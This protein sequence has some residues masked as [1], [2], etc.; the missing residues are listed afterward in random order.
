MK[1]FLTTPIF[2]VNDVPHIGHAYCVLATDVLARFWRSKLGAE[3]VY[4]LT[5]TDENSQKTLDAAEKSGQKVD[6]Y[7]EKMATSWRQTWEKC[8]VSF[9]DFIRTTEKRHHQKVAQVLEKMHRAG[10]IYPG[11]YT[12][13]YCTGCETFL[14]DT[15]LNERGECPDHLKKPQILEEKNYFFRLSKY[16]D[17]LLEFYAKNPNFLRPQKRK[18]EVLAFI[19][20]GLEDISI[21]REGA[22]IGIE[23][24]FDANHRIYVWVEALINYLSACPSDDFWAGA[25]HIV[26]KDIT[27]FH[28]IIWPAMLFSAGISVPNAEFAHGYFTIDGQKMSKS[29]GNVISPLELAEKFG[30]DALRM[31]L[32]ASF[33]FG[34]DGDFGAANFENFYRSQLAGGVGNLFNR[35]VVLAH[36]FFDGQKPQN[37]E[38][39]SRAD[40]E[41][42]ENFLTN[43]EIRGAISFFF[44]KVSDANEFLSRSEIWKT[45]KT[46]PAKA[47]KDF[48]VLAGRLEFLAQMSEILLPKSF[49]KMQKMLGDE[50][51]FGSPEILF[52]EIK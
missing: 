38:N 9:D 48:G 47:Q 4:F 24:P 2:Y 39:V 12:G 19:K 42:F 51:N 20:R 23:F 16:E 11:K 8:D 17:Q 43:F 46:E 27:K 30:T 6:E 18:N 35:V 34:N 21:S 31:G 5:G 13:K 49:G 33:E 29:L 1:K 10:D 37:R 41:T 14:K 3:N 15:D 7:L 40:A 45:A 36:K 25:T 28:S 32:L 50:K 26:G 44:Q 52:G 22:S